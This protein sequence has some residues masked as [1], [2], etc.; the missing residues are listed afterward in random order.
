MMEAFP[1]LATARDYLHQGNYLT[2]DSKNKKPKKRK[3]YDWL[4]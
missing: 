3:E 2:V 4:I 1:S